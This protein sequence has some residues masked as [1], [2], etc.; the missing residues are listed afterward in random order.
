VT[1]TRVAIDPFDSALILHG[2]VIPHAFVP[3]FSVMIWR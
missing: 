1:I 3:A 2:D